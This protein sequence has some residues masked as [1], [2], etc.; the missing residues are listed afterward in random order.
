MLFSSNFVLNLSANK[1][2]YFERK[3]AATVND[4]TG[5]TSF[6]IQSLEYLSDY[7]V[8]QV[9]KTTQPKESKICTCKRDD[10]NSTQPPSR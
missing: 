4:A 8:K 5:I 7:V 9:I 3:P 1:I 2:L 6:E 10:R